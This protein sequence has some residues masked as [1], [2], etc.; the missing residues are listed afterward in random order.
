[1][2]RNSHSPFPVLSLSQQKAGVL[3]MAF[4]WEWMVSWG[5][6]GVALGCC[7]F[8]RLCVCVRDGL[9]ASKAAGLSHRRTL[10]RSGKVALCLGP[11]VHAA[12]SPVRDTSCLQRCYGKRYDWAAISKERFRGWAFPAGAPLFLPVGCLLQRWLP[13]SFAINRTSNATNGLPQNVTW[14]ILIWS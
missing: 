4:G 3:A 6:A 14:P 5:Q 13:S 7:V 10:L 12:D 1:M 9:R 2:A 11:W 8:R